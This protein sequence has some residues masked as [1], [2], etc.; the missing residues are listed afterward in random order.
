M[1]RRCL[2][3]NNRHQI[4]KL[5]RLIISQTKITPSTNSSTPGR[6]SIISRSRRRSRWTITLIKCKITLQSMSGPIW[7]RV[8]NYAS[9]FYKTQNPNKIRSSGIPP[10]AKRSSSV[11]TVWR[12][13]CSAR[14]TG[15]ARW[16]LQSLTAWRSQGPTRWSRSFS[17]SHCR[18]LKTIVDRFTTQL[19]TIMWMWGSSQIGATNRIRFWARFRKSI[20]LW[21][22]CCSRPG[23]RSRTTRPPRARRCAP[24]ATTPRKR[25]TPTE[26]PQIGFTKCT[27][28]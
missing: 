10:T 13:W 23:A 11:W 6:L 26:Q 24:Q 27:Q 17:A 20:T 12:L 22:F 19:K 8:S 14:S 4:P 3:T 21:Q 1:Y 2:K 16:T 15:R 25:I 7:P 5:R 9:N 18:N 28:I